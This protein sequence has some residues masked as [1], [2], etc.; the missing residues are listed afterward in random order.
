M[1]DRIL[2]PE[3]ESD[4]VLRSLD[5]TLRSIAC[6]AESA[7]EMTDSSALV[8]VIRD[9]ADQAIIWADLAFHG[10]PEEVNCTHPDDGAIEA[11][12]LVARSTAGLAGR[13]RSSRARLGPE[14]RR[15]VTCCAADLDAHARWAAEHLREVEVKGFG[16][17]L[18]SAWSRLPSRQE[19]LE[20]FSVLSTRR[21][22][23]PPIPAAA[24]CPASG[25]GASSAA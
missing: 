3:S 10:L 5:L 4:W 11:A 24:P 6:L 2:E 21:A 15:A 19:F 20:P 7:A 8:P 14:V 16:E 17:R 22:S 1:D 13:F 23:E 25:E 18:R 12:M 9:L